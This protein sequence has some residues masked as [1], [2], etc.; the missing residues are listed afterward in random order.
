MDVHWVRQAER[1]GGTGERLQ[2]LPW[3]D[4]AR[5][6]RF[7]Q[8]AHVAAI[9]ATL[10][11]LHAPRVYDLDRVGPRGAQQPGG[12]ITCPCGFP[13]AQLA[14]QIVVVA[15]Q[16]EEPGIDDR[17][18]V[19]LRVR[20]PRGDGRHRRFHRRRVAEPRVAVS[21]RERARD[22][23]PAAGARDRAIV[24]PRSGHG[25]GR[26]LFREQPP[27]MIHARPG[28]MRVDVDA[29]GH[30]DHA[31]GVESPSACRQLGYDAVAL[32]AHVA[33]DAG[34]P[35]VRGVVHR[36]AGDAQL[37][38]LA[39]GPSRSRRARMVT[40]AARAPSNDGRRGNGTSSM[41]N[42]VPPSWIPATPASTA[43]AGWN[44]AALARGPITTLRTRASAVA[45]GT[46]RAAGAPMTSAAS[47][48]PA[49]S[50]APPPVCG[51]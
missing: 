25:I 39:H 29:A 8:T 40:R 43:T 9:T 46:G 30:H 31:A 5:A 26:M 45:T 10:P 36:A 32:D 51:W 17:S 35:S 2:D 41:R 20:V 21:G 12:V 15:E 7:V 23:A 1:V 14:E 34:P 3:R 22:R 38:G 42:A 50:S 11:H 24:E 37:R 33:H 19:E 16:H 48:S 27:G 13:R 4:G 28:D 44:V 18:V 47:T 6:D 49:P